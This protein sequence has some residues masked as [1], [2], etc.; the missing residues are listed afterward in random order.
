MSDSSPY[1]IKSSWPH[2]FIDHP[3][4]A[5][6]WACLILLLGVQSYRSIQVRQFPFIPSGV[7]T[8]TALYPGAD[9][10]QVL[11]RVTTP[12]QRAVSQSESFDYVQST[13]QDGGV[14]IEARLS[15]GQDIDKIFPSVLASIQSTKRSL[16]QDLEDPVLIKGKGNNISLMYVAYTSPSNSTTHSSE[17]YQYLNT[18]IRPQLLMI[19]GIGVVDILGAQPLA[20]RVWLN[21]EDL[22]RYQLSADQIVTA[23][24]KENT[25]VPGGFLETNDYR[26]TLR[27]H[28]EATSLDQVGNIIVGSFDN[29][30]IYLRELAS[31]ELGG[32]NEDSEVI[33][34]EKKGVFLSIDTQPNANALTVIEVVKK[35]LEFL[36]KQLPAHLEQKIVYDATQFIEHSIMEVFKT[37]FEATAIV[38]VM[39]YLCLGSFRAA[40]IPLVAIP[41]SLIGVLI[42]M[43]IVGMSLNLLTLLAMILAIGLVVDDAILVVEHTVYW[44]THIS[45]PILAAKQAISSIQGP[46]IVMTII[47]AVA[48][49]PLAFLGGLTGFL[50]KEFALTLAGSVLISGLVALIISPVLSAFILPAQAWP[51]PPWLKRWTEKYAS[52]LHQILKQP[53]IILQFGIL[54]YPLTIIFF[55]FLPHDLA[56]KEDQGFALLSYQGPKTVPLTYTKKQ[57]EEMLPYIR[58]QPQIRDHFFI[59]GSSGVSGGFGGLIAQPWSDRRDSMETITRSFSEDFRTISGLEIYA[60]T[61]NPLPGPDGLPVQWVIYGPHS[62]EKLYEIAQNMKT[63]LEKTGFF[64]F[65]TTDLK[66]NKINRVIDM[67]KEF[68]AANTLSTLQ[69]ANNI[70]L[71]LNDIP[72]SSVVYQNEEIDL[73]LRQKDRSVE[74]LWNGLGLI[75]QNDT[76]YHFQDLVSSRFEVVPSSVAQFNQLNAVTIQG[77]TFPFVTIGDV[78][79]TTQKFQSDLEVQG[80]F[81]DYTGPMRSFIQ[82]GNQLLWTGLAA[83]IVIYL[84]LLALFENFIDPFLIIMTIPLA[85]CGALSCMNLSCLV[86]T[87]SGNNSLS[88]SFN[89]YTQLGLLTLLGLITKHGILLVDVAKNLRKTQS[90][91]LRE[92]IEQAAHER[93]RPILMT[94]VAMVAGVSPLLFAKGPGAASRYHLGFVLVSGLSLGTLFTLLVFPCIYV[95]IYNKLEKTHKA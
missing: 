75:Y 60:F 40:I 84:V 5:L 74:G 89:I 23:I 94:T 34:N 65:L 43:P 17:I 76:S 59:N 8:V 86:G 54:L 91:S 11:S 3:F 21:K 71:N 37:L 70:M 2:V 33:F 67:D 16:P 45:N 47:L 48:Y 20:V 46:L 90:L 36:Q 57:A 53:R 29:S 18:V 4:W 50:F 24:K 66:I 52:L 12:L 1:P 79:K 44:R 92:S 61:P 62:S 32:Q 56:P 49:L 25:A 69:V 85:L 28:I 81:M 7:I 9:L 72:N 88:I 78:V 39:I 80:C 31:I 41:F 95:F 26:E 83:V 42:L 38:I 93:F 73:R 64:P 13:T 51:D 27:L 14:V 55:L 10:Q 6:S 87:L 19:K 30:P 77:V 63:A 15:L 68:L 22:D 82:E 35:Q 58:R